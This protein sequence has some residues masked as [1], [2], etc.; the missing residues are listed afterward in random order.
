MVVQASYAGKLSQKLEG[1]RFWDA[2]VFEPDPLTGAPASA[3]NAN[4]RVYFPQT[5]G[6]YSTQNR[7]LGNDYRASYSSAQI[8][9]DKRFSHGFS[10]LGS[11]VFSKLLD[12]LVASS[13]GLT[14]GEDNPFNLK[15]DKGRGNYDHTHVV[16]VSWVCEVSSGELEHRRLPHGA[17]RQSHRVRPFVRHS[18]ERHRSAR[19]RTRPTGFRGYL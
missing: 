10:F 1:H 6:I 4:D 11:Y 13:P 9:L 16:T 14:G 2:A 18:A 8:R 17:E 15:L 19:L 3:V 12:N 5:I 7:I